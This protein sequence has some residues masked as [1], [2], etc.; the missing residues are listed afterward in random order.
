MS[1]WLS[2]VL[3]EHLLVQKDF[4]P[5]L[6][7][8][9][10]FAVISCILHNELSLN[11]INQSY[12]QVTWRSFSFICLYI[13]SLGHHTAASAYFKMCVVFKFM[14]YIYWTLKSFPIQFLSFQDSFNMKLQVIT[15]TNK[16]INIKVSLWNLKKW[17]FKIKVYCRYIDIMTDLSTTVYVWSVFRHPLQ[18]G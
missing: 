4:P 14:Q 3:N 16:R 2:L 17:R 9:G 8:A 13:E 1:Y 5:M 6:Y 11:L 18:P 12:V 7:W 10:L 15:L